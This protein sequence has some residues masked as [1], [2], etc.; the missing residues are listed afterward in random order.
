MSYAKETRVPID[1]TQGEIRK[2]LEKYDARGFAFAEQPDRAF[3]MFQMQQR[4]VKFILPMPKRPD[5][6]AT[7]ASRKT[8]QQL[9]RSRWR[10]VLLAIKA[11]LEAVEVGIASFEEEFMAQIVLPNGKTVGEVMTPQITEAYGKGKMPPL[12]GYGNHV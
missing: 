10:A 1:R 12:L 3:I 2:T 7:E 5:S 6:G 8:Y 9:S 11:K 4:M